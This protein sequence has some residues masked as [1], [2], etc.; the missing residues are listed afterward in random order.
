MWCAPQRLDIRL[1]DI[2]LEDP[3]PLHFYGIG[4]GTKLDVLKPY[5]NVKIL[6]NRGAAIYWRLDRKDAIKEVKVK[7][8]AAQSLV[9]IRFYLY[10]GFLHDHGTSQA[11]IADQSSFNEIRGIQEGNVSTAGMRLY[12][13]KDDGDKF[14][15]LDDDETVDNCNIKDG[16]NLFLL[17]Y[18]WLH[19][20]GDV[21][22]LKTKSK[23]EGVEPDETSLGIKVKVQ[24]QI[25]LRASSL[26]LLRGSSLDITQYSSLGTSIQ[27]TDRPLMSKEKASLVVV[28]VEEL[29]DEHFRRQEERKAQEEKEAEEA[30]RQQA[31]NEKRQREYLEAE[32]A[33]AGITV[34]EYLLWLKRR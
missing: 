14:E 13:I 10:Y 11:T 1:G 24:D 27:D 4:N 30:E 3:I 7:L 22:V 16:N 21:T 26:T 29:R 17:T 32:A 8:G 23:I 15:E 28:T 25:G 31:L 5:V 2:T 6:N 33:K 20:E 19:H 34:E 12:I 9:P 18:R